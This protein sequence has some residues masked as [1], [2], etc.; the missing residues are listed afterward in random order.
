MDII[1]LIK[2]INEEKK[3]IYDF[4]KQRLGIT[5]KHI[6]KDSLNNI[7]RYGIYRGKKVLFI[8]SNENDKDFN[9]KIRYAL[10][11]KK[12][13]KNKTQSNIIKSANNYTMSILLEN[14]LW[15]TLLKYVLSKTTFHPTVLIMPH[16]IS[17]ILIK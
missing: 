17:E 9:E 16:L 1:Q 8:I 12:N 5:T 2:R 3:K 13:T 4:N 6:Y 15:I 7:F 14:I 10:E 11:Y